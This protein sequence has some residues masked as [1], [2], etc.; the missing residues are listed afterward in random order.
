MLTWR[1][2]CDVTH[3]KRSKDTSVFMT[4]SYGMI[5]KSS[6]VARAGIFNY[7]MFYLGSQP[8]GAGTPFVPNTTLSTAVDWSCFTPSNV[9]V[10]GLDLAWDWGASQFGCCPKTA[11][12]LASTATLSFPTS[13]PTFPPSE[14]SPSSSVGGDGGGDGGG[15]GGGGERHPS[16]AAAALAA[17]QQGASPRRV[18]FGWQQ[19][20]GSDGGAANSNS[21]ENACTLPRDLSIDP[22]TGNMLQQYIPELQ[23]L[24]IPASR[25]TAESLSFPSTGATMLPSSKAAGNQLEIVA[26]S[27]SHPPS[28]S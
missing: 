24:R 12:G 3:L 9:T 8:A 22:A 4:S 16:T 20:G 14:S 17:L 18:M 27:D 5:G 25:Y 21:T 26:S 11:A 13:S 1:N 7:A 10:G 23:R 19:N 28:T 15:G 2:F 6:G